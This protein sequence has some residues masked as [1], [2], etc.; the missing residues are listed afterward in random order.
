MT[1]DSRDVAIETV[2]RFLRL[3]EARDLEQAGPFL[4]DGVQITFPGGRVFTNLQQQVDSSAGRFRGVRKTFD[5][6][7]VVAEGDGSVVYVF[8]TLSGEHLDGTQF[9]G[10]RFIDRFTLRAG[11]IID[12]MVWNDLAEA[13]VVGPSRTS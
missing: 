6:F 11:Q 10:V 12:Q 9:E 5:R 2:T 4:A 8:G 13:G 7:D 1:D 3:V